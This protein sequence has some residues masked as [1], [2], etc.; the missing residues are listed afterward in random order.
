MKT[1]WFSSI[2]VIRNSSSSMTFRMAVSLTKK[3]LVQTA[4][5]TE[6]LQ[7]SFA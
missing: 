3:L 2:L 7:V 4:A 6:H 5:V 1:E